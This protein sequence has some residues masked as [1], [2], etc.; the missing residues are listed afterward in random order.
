MV[1]AF[2]IKRDYME[3]IFE[4]EPQKQKYSNKKASEY[5]LLG[6]D[7]SNEIE[8]QT[9]V[10]FAS[11]NEQDFELEEVE[12]EREREY[13]MQ[14]PYNTLEDLIIISNKGNFK[15]SFLTKTPSFFTFA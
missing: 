5:S 7:S 10:K 14:T 1:I 9:I 2:G 15:L 12:V 4:D 3:D 13:L 8:M 6:I 11:E